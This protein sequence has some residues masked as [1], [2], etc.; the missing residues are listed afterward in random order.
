MSIDTI[1]WLN[2]THF[3]SMTAIVEFSL[4]GCL[5]VLLVSFYYVGKIQSF[6]NCPLL[7]AISVSLGKLLRNLYSAFK[8]IKS[9][10]TYGLENFY[11]S[12]LP[13]QKISSRAKKI[14]CKLWFPGEKKKKSNQFCKLSS[15][16][17]KESEVSQQIETEWVRWDISYQSDPQSML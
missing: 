10:N 8:P 11:G 14:F 15:L 9:L 7:P 2:I 6:K 13:S 12:R 1:C 4:F 5:W 17:K 16:V 3:V